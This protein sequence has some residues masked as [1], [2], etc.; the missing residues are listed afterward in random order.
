MTEGGDAGRCGARELR[1]VAHQDDELLFMN[2]DLLESLHA[3]HCAR[4][5]YLTAGD[6]GKGV[7]YASTRD[8][9]MRAVYAEMAGRADH[10]T[11]S[12]ATF[13][14]KTISISSLDDSDVSLAFLRLPD[15]GDGSGFPATGQESMTK[16]VSGA[17]ASIHAVDGSNTF[18]RVELVNTLAEL[19]AAYQP[20]WIGLQEIADEFGGDHPDHVA[21]GAM[22]NDAQ[23]RYATP[24]S[25][26]AH[27]GYDTV[28]LPSNLPSS[29][30]DENWKLFID[31]A[32]HDANVCPG[33]TCPALGARPTERVLGLYYDWCRQQLPYFKGSIVGFGG[34]CLTVRGGSTSAGA[35]VDLK[36]CSA[37]DPQRWTFTASDGHLK[38][39][40]LCLEAPGGA[41]SPLRMAAC[42]TTPQQRWTY[43]QVVVGDAGL[44]STRLSPA[45]GICMSVP[46]VA[47]ST[48]GAIGLAACV[49]TSSEQGFWYYAGK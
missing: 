24:H 36:T 1:I 30:A 11:E 28:V 32:K 49:A 7:A 18:T 22:A 4:T 19:V 21:G 46:S 3:G 16:L 34:K 8:A 31:Y 14:G 15:G 5:V 38:A 25:M 6:A 37:S 10:W 17:L 12:T 13:G 48:D 26:V 27:R 42:Q 44:T 9:G 29:L 41:G 2:P 47:S 33:G 39:L 43:G 40:G 45:A 35:A 23:T 20:D